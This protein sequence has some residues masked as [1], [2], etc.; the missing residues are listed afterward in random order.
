MAALA[1]G[2]RTTPHEH[3]R[4]LKIEVHLRR[5]HDGQI[6]HSTIYHILKCLG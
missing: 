3:F 4:Q 2:L 6:G 5:Y 1:E